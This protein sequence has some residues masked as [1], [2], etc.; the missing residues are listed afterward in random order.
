MGALKRPLQ[1]FIIEPFYWLCR[2]FFQPARFQKD[3]A[4][5]PLLMRIKVMLRLFL[6]IFLC[7]YPLALLIR[8]GLFLLSPHLYNHY[9]TPAL[10]FDIFFFLF[11]A[12]WATILSCSVGSLFGSLF[13][14]EYGI[15]FGLTDSIV[16]GIIIH[17]S[18]ATLIMLLC[19]VAAG[20]LLGLTFNS[21]QV[22]KRS[23]FKTTSLGVIYGISAGSVI[24]FVTGIFCG[25]GAGSALLFLGGFFGHLHPHNRGGDSR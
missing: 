2:C 15:V 12:T 21:T 4:Q 14:V 9:F 1:Y 24:G 22:M 25:F 13:G 3:F 16:N 20:L 19:G 10:D 8:I 17:M 5:I 18:N 11:D 6:P 23:G 7:T